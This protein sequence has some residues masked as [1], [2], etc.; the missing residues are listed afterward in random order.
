MVKNNVMVDSQKIIS[1]MLLTITWTIDFNWSQ[2][3][4]NRTFSISKCES[5][6]HLI[7]PL[8]QS[9]HVAF[10]ACWQHPNCIGN[11]WYLHWDGL[12]VHTIQSRWTHHFCWFQNFLYNWLDHYNFFVIE[13]F[14]A[15]LWSDLLSATSLP[16]WRAIGILIVLHCNRFKLSLNNLKPLVYVIPFR[17]QWNFLCSRSWKLARW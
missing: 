2:F 8:H 7:D 4:L 9:D 17:K 5:I 12:A 6:S 16:V 3:L 11:N 1:C 13:R 14:S 10:G 15:L